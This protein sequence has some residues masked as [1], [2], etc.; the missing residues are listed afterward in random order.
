MTTAQNTAD[1]AKTKAEAAQSRADAAYTLAEGKATLADV[2]TAGY[3]LKTEAQAMADA[4]KGDSNDGL[5]DATVYGA[6]AIANKAREEAASAQA[7]ADSK[8]TMKDVEDKGYATVT[9][10]N[11]KA[12]E[13]LGSDAD[14]AEDFTIHGAHKAAAAALARAEVGVENAAIAQGAA[15]SA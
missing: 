7:T 3:A 8:V 14:D 6:I 2:A 15:E 12:G 10:L 5:N 9:Q 11:T 4:V 13:L 1:A